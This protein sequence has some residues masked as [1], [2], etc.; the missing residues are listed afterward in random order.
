[1]YMYMYHHVPHVW[2]MSLIIN[3]L[4]YNYNMF[5]LNGMK[6]NG[7]KFQLIIFNRQVTNSNVSMHVDGHVIENES[8]VYI[9]MTY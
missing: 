4:Q 3:K 7:N 5:R 2:N 9:L 8:V 6:F 1:M